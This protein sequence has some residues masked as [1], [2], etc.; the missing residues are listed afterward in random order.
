MRHVCFHQVRHPNAK[1]TNLSGVLCFFQEVLGSH[2]AGVPTRH[3]PRA[4]PF[5]Y[6]VLASAK[7]DARAFKMAL[8]GLFVSAPLN[9]YLVGTLQK[10]FAGKTGCG[11]K[12]S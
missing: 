10:V 5:Y 9:H 4:S 3:P 6:H 2:F 7:V 12:L 1:L 8:Y 11:A